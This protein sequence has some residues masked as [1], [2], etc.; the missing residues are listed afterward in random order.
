[1]GYG[2][3]APLIY[4]PMGYGYGQ[5]W[6]GMAMAMAMDRCHYAMGYGHIGPYS[7]TYGHTRLY[8]GL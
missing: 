1:M 5:V 8:K 7:A 6:P 3:M 2:H 4:G